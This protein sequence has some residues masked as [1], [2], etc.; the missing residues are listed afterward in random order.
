MFMQKKN[1]IKITRMAVHTTSPHSVACIIYNMC[2]I[3]TNDL[4]AWS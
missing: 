1:K 2:N 4:T 3:K